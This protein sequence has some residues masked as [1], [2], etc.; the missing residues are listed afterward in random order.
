MPIRILYLN[1]RKKQ[2]T[3]SKGRLNKNLK[4]KFVRS[5]LVKSYSMLKAR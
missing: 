3:F 2:L 5:P 4:T 1:L